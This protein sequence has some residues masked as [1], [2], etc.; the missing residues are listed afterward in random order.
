MGV[1]PSGCRAWRMA[2]MPQG[3]W[4]ANLSQ[5]TATAACQRTTCFFLHNIRCVLLQSSP[6][7]AACE[8]KPFTMHWLSHPP[9]TLLCVKVQQSCNLPAVRHQVGF[10][11]CGGGLHQGVQCILNLQQ[12]KHP[13]LRQSY[14][15]GLHHCVHNANNTRAGITPAFSCCA[16][17]ST[18]V[19]IRSG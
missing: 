16:L 4:M 8:G 13:R 2:M 10:C 5:Q 15:E 9:L 19:C 12:K 18:T 3:S 14:S 6:I 17:L 11:A 1:W 7:C